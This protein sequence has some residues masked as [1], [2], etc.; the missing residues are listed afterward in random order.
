MGE[1]GNCKILRIWRHRDSNAKPEISG[2]VSCGLQALAIVHTA[3]NHLESKCL[4]RLLG[5]E[6]VDP[7][8]G[9][10]FMAAL[11]AGPLLCCSEK[12]RANSV[13]PMLRRDK[14]ALDKADRMC[15]IA[16]VSVRAQTSVNKTCDATVRGLGQK[17][18]C[19]ESA[20]RLS[21][22]ER[23]HFSHMR[24]STRIRPQQ[25]AHGTERRSIARFGPADNK[26]F[27]YDMIKAFSF[28][29]SGL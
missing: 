25:V 12:L 2:S 27:H 9:R 10:H 29:G 5:I 15:R 14:P 17:D 1:T 21:C 22:K 24:F 20:A 8:I 6:M 19:R 28:P 18:N 11:I 13:A 4:M 7:C 23:I 3:V 26:L 16:T